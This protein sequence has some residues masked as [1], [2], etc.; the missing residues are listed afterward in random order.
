MTIDYQHLTVYNSTGRKEFSFID[1][2]SKKR[3]D[4]MAKAG[5]YERWKEDFNLVKDMGIEFLRYGLP[6]YKVHTA[7]N[8]YD[9][10]FT[11]ETF[12]YLQELNIEPIV[13]LCHF[14]VPDWMGSFQNPGTF[15]MHRDSAPLKVF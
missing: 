6:Y 9:W 5:H 7:P 2:T 4:E 12:K 14:G 15:Q 13:D 8:Q 1:T 3:V 11:D 10:L